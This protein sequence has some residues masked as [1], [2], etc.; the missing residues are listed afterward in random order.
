MYRTE[1]SIK[2]C[3]TTGCLNRWWLGV[4]T[5]RSSRFS[6]TG[7]NGLAI[8]ICLTKSKVIVN[9][10]NVTRLYSR[11]ANIYFLQLRTICSQIPHKCITPGKLKIHMICPR[12]GCSKVSWF[13][14]LK[15]SLNSRAAPTKIVPTSLMISWDFPCVAKHLVIAI[16]QASMSSPLAT[17]MWTIL[18]TKHVNKQHQCFTE[19]CKIVTSNGPKSSTAVFSKGFALYSMRSFGKSAMWDW[20]I[21]QPASS[22]WCNWFWCCAIVFV[23][24]KPKIVVRPGFSHTL[25]PHGGRLKAFLLRMLS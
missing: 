13:H 17:S 9:T 8:N 15:H 4:S 20:N 7:I 1:S 16:M 11:I 10:G 19:L 12:T 22:I 24:Q 18:L 23:G 6:V 14:S 5:S 25:F 3:A 2:V 21:A